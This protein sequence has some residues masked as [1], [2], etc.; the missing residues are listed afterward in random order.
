MAKKINKNNTQT[1]VNKDTNH[2]KKLLK[3]KKKK[4]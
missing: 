1:K 3:K 2:K 4:N